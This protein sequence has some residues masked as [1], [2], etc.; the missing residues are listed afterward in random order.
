[1]SIE[2]TALEQAQICGNEIAGDQLDDVTGRQLAD[3]NRDGLA[4]ASD[5]RLH[6]HR[7]AQGRHRILRSRILDK[8]EDDAQHHDDDDDDKSGDAARQRG[9]AGRY[10]EYDDQRVLKTEEELAPERN[11][12]HVRRVVFSICLEPGPE[13]RSR[14]TLDLRLQSGRRRAAGSRQISSGPGS[15]DSASAGVTGSEGMSGGGGIGLVRRSGVFVF[16]CSLKL[17]SIYFHCC[18]PFFVFGIEVDCGRARD[19]T[20]F[21]EP[22]KSPTLT[23]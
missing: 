18:M 17:V 3:G 7:R 19:N 10:Q 8:I 12:F 5:S 14:Q 16:W 22:E 15:P 4:V 6:G 2:V 1:M 11:S 20:V 23:I 21:A 9:H 13:V